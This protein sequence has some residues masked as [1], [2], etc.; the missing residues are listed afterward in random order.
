[1]TKESGSLSKDLSPG[2]SGRERINPALSKVECGEGNKKKHQPFR[3][4][5]ESSISFV[6]PA[7]PAPYRNRGPESS[8]SGSRLSSGWLI[9]NF[10]FPSLLLGI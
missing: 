3:C 10:D 2:E 5:P 6:I 8:F 9:N 1:M 7:Q 4:K